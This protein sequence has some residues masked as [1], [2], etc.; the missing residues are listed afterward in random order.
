MCPEKISQRMIHR[1][2]DLVPCVIYAKQ[3]TAA[4]R[5]K[6]MRLTVI[7]IGV[8]FSDVVGKDRSS[9]YIGLYQ[10]H[11]KRTENSKRFIHR[12]PEFFP[13][14]HLT[15]VVFDQECGRLFFYAGD[16]LHYTA[17][18]DREALCINIALSH[19]Y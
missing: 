19:G 12:C 10:F 18:I 11:L 9:A 1:K 3:V 6:G 4:F 16:E 8:S 14:D 7:R 15:C 13:V 2:Q 17:R 5:T